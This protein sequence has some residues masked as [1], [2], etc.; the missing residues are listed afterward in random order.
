[1]FQF[2]K[3]TLLACLM[4]VSAGTWAAAN[5]APKWSVGELTDFADV[6]VTGRVES[7]AGGWDPA[8]NTIYTYV[9]VDV[10]DV[11][12]GPVS[13]GR[14]VLKQLGGSAGDTSL[15]VADQPAF[16]VGE[17]VLLYLEARPRDGSLYT[18]ALWQGKWNVEDNGGEPMAVR[19]EPAGRRSAYPVDRESVSAVRSRSAA[20]DANAVELVEIAPS[21]AAS[22][23]PQPFTLLGPYRYNFNPTIVMQAGGQPGLAGGGV[24]ETQSSIAKWN[25]VG[26]AFQYGFGGATGAPRCTST[27]VGNSLVTISYNDP[28]GE[29]SDAGGTLAVGGSYFSNTPGA[30]GTVNGQAFFR[31]LEGFVVNNNSA[32]ATQFLTRTGCFADIQLHEIGH[33][34]GLNHSADNTAIMFA[35]ISNT[36]INGPNNLNAD[37]RNGILFIYP[38]TGGITPPG[39]APTGLAVVVNGTASITVSFNAVAALAAEPSAATGYRLDF[40]Q[41]VNGP[42][43]AS[44]TTATTSTTIPLPPGTLGTFNVV[45]TGVNS[46]G[47]GPSSA[48]VTFTIGGGPGPCVAPPASPVVSGGV[49]GGTATVS[50]PQVAG[51]TSYIL[52]AG[53]TPGAGNLFPATNIGL[54]NVASASGLPPGFTAFVRV[55]AVNACGSSAPTDFFV[56]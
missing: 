14:I 40:R 20:Y 43:V 56:Q 47:A 42:I 6:I 16:T 33:V 30:G 1:M 54:N 23:T 49:V 28:C 53:T 4:I 21:D 27:F 32:T 38:P 50:W 48:P 17:R 52:S 51:A 10:D 3:A 41:V 8:V 45:A 26:A 46:A 12:K 36:C 31:A 22:A 34:L 25:A 35:S 39:S 55:I 37:D 2:R 9:T 7:V 24:A 5:L 29:V 19:Y 13:R 44:L 18:S 15:M 11:F